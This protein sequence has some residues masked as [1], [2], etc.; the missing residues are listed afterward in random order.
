MY[1]Y[2][3]SK[4]HMKS[5]FHLGFFLSHSANFCSFC[6]FSVLFKQIIITRASAV[7]EVWGGEGGCTPLWGFS[8][9]SVHPSL[10]IGPAFG[11]RVNLEGYKLI[12]EGQSY[13]VASPRLPSPPLQDGMTLP[14]FYRWLTFSFQDMNH[15]TL[16]DVRDESLL[17][18][19][20][21][22]LF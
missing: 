18:H 9:H 13:R 1:L 6:D 16:A 5:K 22:F 19:R 12:T 10:R 21:S 7:S 14:L 11:L 17:L 2:T 3:L 15:V 20:S 4:N 8:S